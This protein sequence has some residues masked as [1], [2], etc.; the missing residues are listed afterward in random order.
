MSRIDRRTFL[1]LAAMTAATAPAM[2]G[3]KTDTG[4]PTR[5]LGRTGEQV[6]LLGLGGAH[7]SQDPNLTDAQTMRLMRTAIDAGVSFF[8]NA[9]SY[10]QGLSERRM[11]IA[12]ADGYRERVFLMT[13]V[14][15]R[16]ALG[17]QEQLETSLRR[18][19]TDHLDLWQ[20]HAIQTS[21]HVQAVYEGGLLDVALRARED[22][23]IRYIGFTGHTHPQIHLQMIEGGFAWD[24]VQ[25]PINP[26]DAHYLSFVQDVLPVAVEKGI[27][28]IAMKTMGGTS[29]ALPQTGL[30]S[31]AQCLHYAMSL[32][33]S[34]VCSGMDSQEKLEQN[35]ATTR[36]FAPLTGAE[37]VQ[38]VEDSRELGRTGDHE[39]Y[40]A[41]PPQQVLE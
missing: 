28:V 32:P 26:F 22:G 41:R 23:K 11:G 7:L 10:S 1:R 38:L 17:A 3:A 33:V 19:R 25:M 34:T 36:G 20:F 21:E 8:D 39:T 14:E 18:L 37:M 4:L 31:P 16:S 24:T 15:S 27:A 35:L 29:G 2:L 30:L 9:W 6:S 5:I 13:K 40:K 12:L